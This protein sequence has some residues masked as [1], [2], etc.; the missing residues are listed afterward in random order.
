MLNEKFDR[1]SFILDQTARKVKQFAQSSF[2]EKGFDITVDQWTVLKA[3]YETA[4]LSQKE[5]AKRCGKDQPT[6]TRIVDILLK[7][8]LAERITDV[9]DRRSLYLHL[10]QEGKLKVESLSPLVVEIRMKAWENLT[11]SD[12]EDF[13]RIL[14]TIYNNL[15]VQSL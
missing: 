2:A 9:A 5:L 6:L 12:F 3:L 7:K 13:T 15:N 8:N 14:N 1:Y 11:D 4:Q 10:T